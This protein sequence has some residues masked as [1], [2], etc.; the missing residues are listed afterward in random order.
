[1]LDLND[2]IPPGAGWVL[3]DAIDINNDGQI[4]GNGYLD[5]AVRAFLLMP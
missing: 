2:L 3:T 5:G 1:M 4:V